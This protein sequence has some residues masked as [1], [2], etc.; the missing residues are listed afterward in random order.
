MV[1][2]LSCPF[3]GECP[4][5]EDPALGFK[6][7]RS[8]YAI[9]HPE[10]DCILSGYGWGFVTHSDPWNRRAS[11]PLR[12]DLLEALKEVRTQIHNLP[13]S[14]TADHIERVVSAAITRAET[15]E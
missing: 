5:I 7:S 4:R 13:R 3:C 15:T 9:R 14:M 10:N 6:R 8:L 12:A 1:E 2:L 11:D